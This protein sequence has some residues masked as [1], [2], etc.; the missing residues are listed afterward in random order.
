VR[1][2]LP[3]VEEGLAALTASRTLLRDDSRY[4]FA[5]PSL[6][7]YIMFREAAARGLL[8]EAEAAQVAA[9]G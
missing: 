4:T 7:H 9:D 8:D 6:A 2:A 3:V 1:L 5:Q